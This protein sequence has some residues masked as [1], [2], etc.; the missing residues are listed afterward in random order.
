M[1]TFHGASSRLLCPPRADPQSERA[2]GQRGQRLSFEAKQRIPFHFVLAC[3]VSNADASQVCDAISIIRD[4]DEA[5]RCV[6]LDCDLMRETGIGNS[7]LATL[8]SG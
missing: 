3:V 2:Q 7:E 5:F 8:K 4:A 6:D 1:P